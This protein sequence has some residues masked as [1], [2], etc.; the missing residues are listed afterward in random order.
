MGGDA[1]RKSRTDRSV[2]NFAAEL[3]NGIPAESRTGLLTEKLE[4]YF[5]LSTRI[6]D[7]LTQCFVA[8][9]SARPIRHVIQFERQPIVRKESMKDLDGQWARPIGGNDKARRRIRQE[10]S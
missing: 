2:N 7:R 4:D 5:R 3:D 8:N 6:P 10:A 9:F 1:D